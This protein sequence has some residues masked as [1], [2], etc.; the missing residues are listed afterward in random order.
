MQEAIE[1]TQYHH[2]IYS[3]R[4]MK[5]Q[6]PQSI[7]EPHKRK[8]VLL[9]EEMFQRIQQHL[10]DDKS[11]RQAARMESISECAIRILDKEGT[12]E[13][14]DDLCALKYDKCALSLIYSIYT[15]VCQINK[16]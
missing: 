13:K 9:T 14:N 15:A 12:V 8:R 1:F 11:I 3:M 4:D 7:K 2:M 6:E 10:D 16:K 5:P